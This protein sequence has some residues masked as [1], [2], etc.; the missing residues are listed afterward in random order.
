MSELQKIERLNER[1][2]QTRLGGGEERIEA[3]HKKGR[4]TARERLDLLLDVQHRAAT[5]ADE[6]AQSG[7]LLRWGMVCGAHPTGCR[8][9]H[10][11]VFY[12]WFRFLRG[13]RA[14]VVNFV[15]LTTER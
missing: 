1:K 5:A 9:G 4:L 12:L 2:A 10:V 3:Q 8:R 14:S 13:L 6:D 11:V 15:F 7:R